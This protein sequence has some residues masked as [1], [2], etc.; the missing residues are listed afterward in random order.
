MFTLRVF[1]PSRHGMKKTATATVRWKRS[2]GI[3]TV[4]GIKANL[5]EY[6]GAWTRAFGRMASSRVLGPSEGA[7]RPTTLDQLWR[8]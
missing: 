4:Q 7:P 8:R 5:T 6:A 3:V 2:D 1:I